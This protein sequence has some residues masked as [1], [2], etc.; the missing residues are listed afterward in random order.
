MTKPRDPDAL[1]SAY[2]AVGMEVLP[3]RV[4]ESVLAEVHRTRQRRTIP[5]RTPATFRLAFGAAAVVAALVAGGAFA[6]WQG[7]RPAVTT[8]SPTASAS[9][10][11][12]SRQTSSTAV[13]PGG[14]WIATGS[15]GTPRFGHSAVR[16][17]DGR[18]LVVGGYA[19][20]GEN[21]Y[22]PETTSVELYDP[23]TG[24][25]AST[26]NTNRPPWGFPA[27]LLAD[28]RVLVGVDLGD[29]FTEVG[30]RPGAELYDPGSGT[31]S[32]TGPMTRRGAKATLLRDGK[33]LVTGDEGSELFDPSDGTWAATASVSQ[34]RHS[35][36]AIL[37]PDGDVLV[38][39]G[40]SPGDRPA[41]SAELYDPVKDSWTKIA[42]MHAAREAIEAFLRPDGK[43]LVVGGGYQRGTLGAELYDPVTRTWAPGQWNGGDGPS[44]P[45]ITEMS[46]GRVLVVGDRRFELFDADTGTW[47][48]TGTMSGRHS[49]GTATLLADGTVLVAGGGCP[50]TASEC[51]A[52]G[53]SEVYVPNGVSS[54]TGL[55]TPG[56]TPI[57]TPKPSPTPRPT[58]VPAAVGP[59]PTGARTWSV[60][61]TNGAAE[62]ATLF[63][64]EDTVKGMGRLVGSVTP[65]VVPPGTRLKVTF[66]LPADDEGR[67][68]IYVNPSPEYGALLSPGDLPQVLEVFI[69]SD[70]QSSW[71]S[72]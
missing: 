18:V 65:N 67:W 20:F 34:Q 61:V 43:V 3:D 45:I 10:A 56:P 32:A 5:S 25:W 71:S 40:H 23:E 21:G 46:D 37:L 2:L 54:P 1:L 27:T 36:A 55:A 39:G 59:V 15:M 28:G 11:P 38:A 42:N 24:I 57:P 4:V 68:S 58:P 52:S 12:S 19:G 72:R 6:V 16:L 47:T 7:T 31:W 60:T 29:A 49:R 53:F 44:D 51:I 14:A 48:A 62:A 35:H 69:G 8:P 41:S 17:L 9:P 66:Q 63:V 33:V 64:A 26:G 13:A 50:E 30:G 70:G 22:A